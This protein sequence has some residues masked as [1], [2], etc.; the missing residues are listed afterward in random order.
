[1]DL[2]GIILSEINQMEKDK[3]S[4][5]SPSWTSLVAQRLKRLPAMQETQVQSLSW[6]DPLEKEM[7]ATPVFLPGDSHGGRS[8]VGYNPQGR[9]SQTRLSM[10]HRL[11]PEATSLTTDATIHM[12]AQ[13]RP[14]FCDPRGL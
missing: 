2:E 5:I 14:S 13:S 12:C 6:E 3:C 8:L 7:A 1:M 4:M 9:K 10:Q 11:I